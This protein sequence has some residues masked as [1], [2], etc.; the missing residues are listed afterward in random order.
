MKAI[1]I[2]SNGYIARHLV[3]ALIERSIEVLPCGQNAVSVDNHPA[4][5]QLDLTDAQSIE[6]LDFNADAVFLFAGLTG[7]AVGFT[8]YEDY[9][10]VNQIGLLHVLDA[11]R[12]K[13]PSIKIVFPSSR[14]VYK[15]IKDLPLVE[16]SEKEF[17]TLYALTK[18]A[19]EATLDMYR[20]AFGLNYTI[21]R[22][23][24]PYGNLLGGGYSYGT[25]GFMLGKAMKGEAITLF[26]D[27]GQKRTFT[28]VADIC[29]AILDTAFLDISN[30]QTFNIG[31]ETFSL[32]Q[33]ASLIAQKYGVEVLYKEWN[34][35]DLAIE[36]GD[37]IFESS[38][39]DALLDVL[40]KTP[41]RYRFQDWLKTL[42]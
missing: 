36:S 40:S 6:Q 23:C 33:A 10:R 8:K 30:H 22:I 3:R 14:L 21:Y 16:S 29:S 12:R 37:T 31:G 7:T 42:S 2:G 20:N 26:G 18:F 38:K 27:G 34:A 15:G 28:H 4:Y 9:V 32:K 11:I 13:N 35:L 1:V 41:R 5:L 39:L 24:V 19:G 25:I 17:K